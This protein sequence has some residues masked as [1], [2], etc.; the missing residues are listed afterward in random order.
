[1][2]NHKPQDPASNDADDSSLDAPDWM[3]SLYAEG[4][5][6]E[7]PQHI[8]HLILE[9][10][11]T[12]KFDP[13]I[14]GAHR[15]K[16]WGGSIAT[17]AVV[18]L[19]IGIFYDYQ[20]VDLQHSTP[21]PAFKK[22]LQERLDRSAPMAVT[23]VTELEISADQ[24]DEDS[25]KTESIPQ[26]KRVMAS[27]QDSAASKRTVKNPTCDI[28]YEFAADVTRINQQDDGHF[29]FSKDSENYQLECL[30]GEW[31]ERRQP[32]AGSVNME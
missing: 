28:P 14:T 10:A 15:W 26:P 18:V 19:S 4:N 8:D 22:Q 11:A 9:A 32:P 3:R 29:T 17:A 16:K 27:T 24:A 12:K 20:D 6:E 21:Q 13:P 23:T 7:P 30:E 25:Y 1:M 2:S 5:Q 31:V